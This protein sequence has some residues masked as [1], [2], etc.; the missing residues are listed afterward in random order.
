MDAFE[1]GDILPLNQVR[2]IKQ[3]VVALSEQIRQFATVR[4]NITDVMGA[5]STEEF[6]SKS[7]FSINIGSNDIFRLFLDQ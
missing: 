3:K 6:L 4:S 2:N 5:E 1:Y 7:V